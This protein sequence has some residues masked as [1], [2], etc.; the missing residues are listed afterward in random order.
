M[1]SIDRDEGILLE[2][3]KGSQRASASSGR[4]IEEA[5]IERRARKKQSMLTFLKNKSKQPSS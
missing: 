1:T 4:K 2:K 3:G 5:N